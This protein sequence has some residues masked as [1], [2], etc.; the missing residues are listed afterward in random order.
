M[1]QTRFVLR[2]AFLH[3]L[4]AL[5]MINKI[6]RPNARPDEV[7]NEVFDLF[8]ELGAHDEQLEFPVIYGSGRDGYAVTD[9][10]EEPK[11]LQPLFDFILKH[12]P[13]PRCDPAGPLQFQA[14]TLEHDGF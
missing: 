14:A 9:P 4:R 10:R 2:K 13:A 8:V 12:V 7:L 6:D 11:D 3:G 5:V 1:P